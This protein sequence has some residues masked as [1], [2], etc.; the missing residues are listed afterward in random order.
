MSEETG[1]ESVSRFKLMEA[2]DN[3]QIVAEINGEMLK[4]M[5][6]TVKGKNRLSYAG[7]KFAAI[8]LGDIH[9]RESTVTY[10]KELDQFEASAL[11]Y[12]ANNKLTLPGHAEQPRMMKIW[13]DKEKTKFHLEPDDFA[14]RKAASKSVRN[15]LMAVMP[16][17]HIAAY[18]KAMIDK[19]KPR[20]IRNPSPKKVESETVVKPRV[21]D[22]PRQ[23][24][25]KPVEESKEE[26][27]PKGPPKSIDDLTAKIAA[28]LPGHSELVVISDR[29]D[30]YRI[31]RKRTLDTEIENHLDFI[32][33]EMG[34][35]WDNDKNEWRI[36]KK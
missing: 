11:A 6:Y 32:V 36:E 29:G 26:E 10:N 15:A 5:V 24:E 13:D 27:S 23:E 20:V 16:A 14:R 7:A 25:P 2:A 18:M 21:G 22:P 3:A 31:G 34:G 28:F 35:E 33:S 1:I 4:E 17:D 12:N 30:Y 9:V 19:R 8:Q